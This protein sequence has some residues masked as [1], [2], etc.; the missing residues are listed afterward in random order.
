MS[1]PKVFVGS[2]KENLKVAKVLGEELEKHAEVI[3]WDEG[4]FRLNRGI[5]E[6][7]LSK[8]VEF[9]FAVLILAPDD[10]T[11]SRDELK[12]STRDNVLFECGL[13][14]GRL[15][16]DRVFIVYDTSIE[17]KLP[18]DLAGLT[19]APYDG[20]RIEG[21]NAAAAVRKASRLISESIE[22][23]QFSHIVG[24][25]Q[26]KYRLTAETGYPLA[27]EVVDVKPSQ[28]GISII[29]KDNSQNDSYIARG[30]LVKDRYLIGEWNATQ[31]RGSI[32]GAFLLTINPRGTLMYG[33][34]TSQDERFA[35]VYATWVLAKKNGAS[36]DELV[37]RLKIGEELLRE[38]ISIWE[39]IKIE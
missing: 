20:N 22:K 10:M 15:G 27:E 6:E 3:V 16:R 30:K 21:S 33:Y 4:V 19:L 17:L 26:S 5:L 24:E 12:P 9:D 14:M 11:L 8:L 37:E 13:F 7:L 23:P 39:Q 28:G 38:T 34:T 35:T 29:S 36:K 32:D 1:R 31:T 18:S 2:S 25:W